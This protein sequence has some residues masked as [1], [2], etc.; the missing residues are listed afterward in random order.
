MLRESRGWSEDVTLLLGGTDF[1]SISQ[2]A[3]AV[4]SLVRLPGRFN[5]GPC[6]ADEVEQDGCVPAGN[7]LLTS[8]ALSSLVV[9]AAGVTS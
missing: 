5:V 8:A 9:S 3:R 4:S 6:A 1:A 2:T 7:E